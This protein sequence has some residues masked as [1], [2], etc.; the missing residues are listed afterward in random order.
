MFSK[1]LYLRDSECSVGLSDVAL[2][3]YESFLL[4][5]ERWVIYSMLIIEITFQNRGKCGDNRISPRNSQFKS[6]ILTFSKKLRHV[7]SSRHPTY[8]TPDRNYVFIGW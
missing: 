8:S 6:Y 5:P 3:T 4:G 1:A 7:S 2:G